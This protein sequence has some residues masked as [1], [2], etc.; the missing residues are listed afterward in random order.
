MALAKQESI[1][2]R[3]LVICMYLGGACLASC[4]KIFCFVSPQIYASSLIFGG[5]AQRLYAGA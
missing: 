5:Y 4:S 3:T 1:L 2:M